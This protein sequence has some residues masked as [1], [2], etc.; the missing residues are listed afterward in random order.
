MESNTED[1]CGKM[2]RIIKY[3]I[4][5]TKELAKLCIE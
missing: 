4:G 2:A 5:E 1:P 3:I